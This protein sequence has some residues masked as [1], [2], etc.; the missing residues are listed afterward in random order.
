[1]A[2][3]SVSRGERNKQKRLMTVLQVNPMTF[4]CMPF[5]LSF[6]ISLYTYET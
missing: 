6:F 2:S 1:M 3:Q 5:S 4:N